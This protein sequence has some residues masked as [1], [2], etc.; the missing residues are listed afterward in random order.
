M[1]LANSVLFFLLELLIRWVFE[2]FKLSYMFLNCTF[3][4]K[5]YLGE[6]LRGSLNFAGYFFDISSLKDMLFYFNEYI[7][8]SQYFW[9]VFFHIC[10]FLSQVFRKI[11]SCIYRCYDFLYLLRVANILIL[12][13]TYVVLLFVICLQYL[14]PDYW[15]LWLSFLIFFFL[16]VSKCQFS[17]FSFPISICAPL[18]LDIMWFFLI[19]Q[20]NWRGTENASFIFYPWQPV[21][22]GVAWLRTLWLSCVFFPFH[23]S[24]NSCKPTVLGTCSLFSLVSRV[25]QPHPRSLSTHSGSG[26]SLLMVNWYWCL[27]G[28]FL[29]MCLE[30]QPSRFTALIHSSS[31]PDVFFPSWTM[32]LFPFRVEYG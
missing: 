15:Y 6:L 10:L 8:H 29:V 16:F 17:T 19:R 30:S 25:E 12:Y 27:F 3:I 11:L 1:H 32:G 26:P 4:L 7:F 23:S 9:L 13:P 5:P 2:S 18:F 28:A 20:K 31:S 21:N 14:L 24:G 22:E